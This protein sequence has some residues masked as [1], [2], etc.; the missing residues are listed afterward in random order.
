[1]STSPG[2]DAPSRLGLPGARRRARERALELLYEAESKA[3][4]PADLL[5]ELP[6]APEDYAE[7]L[8]TGVERR[9]GDIDDLLARHA[10]GWAVDRMPAVDR[11][12]LRIAAYELL[13]EPDV[14]VAVIIDEA[15][16]L[17]KAYSTE[18]SGRF[19]NGVL[20]GIAAEIRPGVV[21]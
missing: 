2:P 3:I 10:T 1:V 5:S 16:E 6:V 9:T 21:P 19:V 8:V 14:P 13:E 7:V 15:I 18:D 17:V 4:A 11:C 20:A 12:V